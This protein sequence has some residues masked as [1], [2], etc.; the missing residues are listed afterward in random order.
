MKSGGQ[1]IWKK[2]KHAGFRIKSGMT[3]EKAQNDVKKTHR[4]EIFRVMVFP[5][6]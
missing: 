3:E 4:K 5:A 2:E 1:I 6:H